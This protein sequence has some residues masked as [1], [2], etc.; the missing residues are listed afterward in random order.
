MAWKGLEL[1]AGGG[2]EELSEGGV[3]FLEKPCLC[4]SSLLRLPA[5]SESLASVVLGGQAG[6]ELHQSHAPALPQREVRAGGTGL[7]GWGGQEQGTRRWFCLLRLRG[8]EQKEFWKLI[9][10]QTIVQL[11]T[12]K[13]GLGAN[14]P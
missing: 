5:A 9:T 1:V 6:T 4:L 2:G 12:A 14:E 3:L 11:N 13:R 8:K 7:G 10:V